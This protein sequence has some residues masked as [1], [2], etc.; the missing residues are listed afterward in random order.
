VI[1]LHGV[2][3]SHRVWT[4]LGGAH[5]VYD[6]LRKQGLNEFVIVMP[7]DGGHKEGSGYL[8]LQ[9]AN[10]EKWIVED[11]ITTI[12]T[13]MPQCSI[14]SKVYISG[15]SMG[16]YGALRLGAKYPHLFAGIS[17]HSSITKLDD[18]THFVDED[19]LQS[20][21]QHRDKYEADVYKG[22]TANQ[23]LLPPFRFDCGK[24][25][26]LY[27]SNIALVNKLQSLGI[28]YQ[29][30]TFRG[31][32]EWGYWHKHLEDTLQFFAS[33]ESGAN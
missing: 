13:H 21:H 18:F 8:P 27:E 29:F 20:L 3:G 1:L 24:S 5:I 28:S 23:D 9:D 12:Q 17:A 2:Y 4:Q 25:D 6:K 10:Y 19:T 14:N 32:H 11:V 30:D 22:I 15:L 7:S 16:G 33:I 31:E 26:V